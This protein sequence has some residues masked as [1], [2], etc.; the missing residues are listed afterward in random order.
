MDA[1]AL[2]KRAAY[3]V[4]LAIKAGTLKR[5]PKCP[6]CG[7]ASILHAHHHDYSEP[8]EVEWLC[9]WCH[10]EVHAMIVPSAD[11]VRRQYNRPGETIRHRPGPVIPPRSTCI[12]CGREKPFTSFYR[13]AFLGLSERCKRC[14]PRIAVSAAQQRVLDRLRDGKRMWMIE[15]EERTRGVVAQIVTIRALEGKRLVRAVVEGGVTCWEARERWPVPAVRKRPGREGAE[16]VEKTNKCP[17]CGRHGY[18]ALDCK[19]ETR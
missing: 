19:K 1:D 3:N 7:V 17:E 15:G 12:Q 16:V 8:L 13:R 6:R 10:V 2:Q 14:E 4:A 9:R 18:H 11:G 5:P